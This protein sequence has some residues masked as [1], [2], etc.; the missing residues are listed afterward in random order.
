[1][2]DVLTDVLA[3]ARV[4]GAVFA[5][6]EARAPWGLHFEGSRR[7]AFHIVSRGTC[8]LRL[9]DPS[10]T[11]RGGAAVR[12]R[13][14][15]VMFLAQGTG[16]VLSD[17]PATPAVEFAALARHDEGGRPAVGVQAGGMGPATGLVCGAYA[18]DADGP[19]PFLKSLPELIHLTAESLSSGGTLEATVRLLCGEVEARDP[20]AQAVVDRLVDVLLIYVL[21]EWLGRQEEGCPGWFGGLRDPQ[22]GGAL[23]LIHGSP[24][25]RWTIASLGAAVGLSRAAFA[26]RFGALV[27][28]PPMSYLARWRMTLAARALREREDPLS[29]IA[30]RVGY[31]SEFA[32]AKAFKRL[33]GE[34]P[35]RY[36]A[37]SRRTER[38]DEAADNAAG[39]FLETS[40][41]H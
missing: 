22:V 34:A 40:K 9:D 7:A 6:S 8:W 11:R 39:P 15:D 38:R 24:G 5:R 28:E 3:A 21:R 20:G 29:A 14:G 12:L 35:G 4:G 37:R 31:D 16:H 33:H 32:F 41:P 17:D 1:M 26:R 27:G 10:G 19:H 2:V 13:A 23:S 18:F 25:R 30:H 36:R